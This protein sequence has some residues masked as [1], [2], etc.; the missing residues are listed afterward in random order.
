M[1][2]E[3][4][5]PPGTNLEF[6]IIVFKDSAITSKLTQF[7]IMSSQITSRNILLVSIFEQVK[8][9]ISECHNAKV[10]FLLL[11]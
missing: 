5:F 2:M 1:F 8:L 7:D 10:S 6:K 3:V 4:K 11:T 9:K